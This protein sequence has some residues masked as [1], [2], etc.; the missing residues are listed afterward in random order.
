M[1]DRLPEELLE[2]AN[3]LVTLPPNQANLR[4]AV[5]TAYYGLFHLLIRSAVMKWS[6][7]LHQARIARMF[8]HERMKKIC[9]A[10]IK[11]IRAAINLDDSNST[12]ARCRTELITVAQAFILLQQERHNADY[13]LERP[14]D[15]ADA[16]EQVEMSN[17]AFVSWEVAS[18][19]E[20]AREFL[21]SLLFK[22]KERT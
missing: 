19:S 13:N 1:V 2:Q 6:D 16:M 5:S 12:E 7:P 9:G 17:S 21:F 3:L 10:T 20:A 15:R 8:E 11:S 18:G 14:L 22:E 4:R